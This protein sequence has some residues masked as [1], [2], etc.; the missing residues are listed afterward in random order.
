MLATRCCVC[1]KEFAPNPSQAISWSARA[2][3]LSSLWG[4]PVGAGCE[5]RSSVPPATVRWSNTEEAKIPSLETLRKWTLLESVSATSAQKRRA[6]A[7]QLRMLSLEA[8]E[9]IR[10]SFEQ[11]LSATGWHMSRADD[12]L[13][14]R[15]YFQF[16]AQHHEGARRVGMHT[17]V[18]QETSTQGVNSGCHGKEG[19]GVASTT[20]S[21]TPSHHT[22]TDWKGW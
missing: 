9:I 7:Q 19:K 18:L 4:P 22:R 15:G 21:E 8:L 3:Q 20:H 2:D 16:R 12:G 14:V 6:V 5:V 10:A 11:H 13:G 1:Y 17:L